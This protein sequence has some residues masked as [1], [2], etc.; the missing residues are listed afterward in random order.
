MYTELFSGVGA[1]PVSAID[2]VF[3]EDHHDPVF[4]RGVLF[5]SVCEHHLIPFFGLVN[6][7]YIPDQGIAGLSKLARALEVLTHRPQVQERLT[8][9]LADA[10]LAALKPKGVVVEMEAEHLCM[11]MR[12]VKK[13]GSRVITTAIRGDFPGSGMDRDTFL[14]LFRRA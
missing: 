14:T 7:G 6:I 11:S 2:A 13:P 10:I 4:V 5:H 8:R 9:Q 3:Q 12:G 1:D